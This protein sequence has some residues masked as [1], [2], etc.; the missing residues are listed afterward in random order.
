MDCRPLRR[1]FETAQEA[2]RPDLRVLCRLRHA[3]SLDLALGEPLGRTQKEAEQA[4]AF[5]RDARFGIVAD[6]ITA[7][8]AL[9]RRLRG[10]TPSFTSFDDREFSE[11]QFEG[12]L[13]QD[14]R[15]AWAAC[16]YWIRKLQACVF[17]GE[18]ETALD[19][20]ARAEA[21]L[22]TASVLLPG[23]RIPLLRGARL[24]GTVRHGAGRRAGSAPGGAARPW[25]H[26]GVL[27]EELSREL[28]EPRRPRRRRDRPPR[29][30]RSRGD[31][32]LR[33]R[34]S[35]Q[36][37]TTASSTTRRWPTSG[38]AASISTTAS[39]PLASPICATRAPATPAGAPTARCASSTS[40]IR[41]WPPASLR[42]RGD[43]RLGRRPAGCGD[44]DQGLPGGVGRNRS[45]P[46]D[47]D[48]DDHHPAERGRRSRPA[49]AAP[50]RDLRDRGG[51]PR[52]RRRR[53][54]AAAP[55]GHD[56]PRTAPRP[57]STS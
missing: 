47:R 32:P 50:R 14:S 38:R 55:R 28:R 8:L 4:L 17:A 48:A 10:L 41:N 21:L 22:W 33:G 44:P 31:A 6:I 42:R 25:R 24:C 3:I 43:A 19:A 16:F 46:P 30:P 20:A 54:G 2:R 34:P 45:A 57:S 53:R 29:G 13:G 26:A 5:V 37:G 40:S 51:G 56:R 39:R 1:G 35:A 52:R 27:G 18:Y 36:P 12:R 23:G 15:L 7:N 9:I 11:G 49:A